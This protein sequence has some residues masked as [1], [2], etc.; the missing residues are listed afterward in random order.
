[1]NADS[2]AKLDIELVLTYFFSKS[3][4]KNKR[5]ICGGSLPDKIRLRKCGRHP[6]LF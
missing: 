5:E 1:M 6:I 2:D 3:V 4:F